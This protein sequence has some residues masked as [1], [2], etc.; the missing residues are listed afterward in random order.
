MKKHIYINVG[1][2][3]ILCLLYI[4]LADYYSF[5]W[6]D[7]IYFS[8][9]AANLIDGR[10][11]YTEGIGN[12]YPPLYSLMLAG[13]FLIFGV[14]H[15]A[16]VAMEILLAFCAYIVIL[17]F[18]ERHCLFTKPVSYY[19]L[20]PL[21]W[22]GFYMPTVFT[23][24]RV[25]MLV[26]L[27]VLLLIDEILPTNEKNVYNKWKL[28]GL[29]FLLALSAIYPLPFT[30]FVILFFLISS[31]AANRRI[32][33]K[34]G[35][36]VLSGILLGLIATIVFSYYNGYL[37]E[38][39]SWIGGGRSKVD[40]FI[41]K[42]PHAYSD[43]PTIAIYLITTTIIFFRKLNRIPLKILIFIAM[44]PS[45]M[46]LVGRFERYYWW[47]MYIPTIVIF[48][49]SIVSQSKVHNVLSIA[50]VSLICVMSQMFLCQY[51]QRYSHDYFNLD[52]NKTLFEYQHEKALADRMVTD[53]KEELDNCAFVSE[54]FYYPLFNNGSTNWF[55]F[56]GH[57]P[58]S[59]KSVIV[60]H[61]RS[62]FYW[63]IYEDYIRGY[64]KDEFPSKGVFFSLENRHTIDCI[65]FLKKENYKYHEYV[66]DVKTQAKIITFEKQQ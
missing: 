8:S 13:W 43:I 31:G 22:L 2:A 5:A 35:L 25:D 38:F 37:A 34:I 52:Y 19:I 27:L 44:I 55:V 62:K 49:M 21:Y 47:M 7:E 6:C 54:L 18:V 24:G 40:A 17:R 15:T 59:Q 32:Y 46:M 58:K 20:I 3:F 41:H 28:I 29:S 12:P 9:P 10:A 11:W 42:I 53:F 1:V 56:I 16:A 48:I 30:V 45:L 50:I 4:C 36:F 66:V 26:M 39:L 61:D 33:F 51:P 63:R 65:A 14:S 60:R 57:F 23:M 64:A